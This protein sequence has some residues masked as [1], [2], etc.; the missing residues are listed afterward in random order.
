MVLKRISEMVTT[1]VFSSLLIIEN[2]VYIWSKHKNIKNL[3]QPS[4]NFNNYKH[5]AIMIYLYFWLIS[6]SIILTIIM[7]MTTILWV[8]IMIITI[9]IMGLH[10]TY[11]SYTKG[12]EISVKKTLTNGYSYITQ[13]I[14][15]IEH[16]HLPEIV[17][18]S[19]HNYNPSPLRSL[20]WFRSLK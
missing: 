19:L 10:L 14:H 11:V 16:F 15:D 12:I 17:L 7:V 13:T 20:F 18:V 8:K 9:I 3:Y 5:S 4:H 1:F 2:A 6:H